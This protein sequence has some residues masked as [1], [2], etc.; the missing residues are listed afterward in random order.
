MTVNPVHLKLMFFFE[1]I[2]SRYEICHF[3]IIFFN[4][5]SKFNS[6]IPIVVVDLVNSLVKSFKS[7]PCS[8]SPSVFQFFD[9]S[10][11]AILVL[12]CYPDT[13]SFFFKTAAH[14]S[15]AHFKVNP[16]YFTNDLVSRND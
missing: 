14:G 10:P 7:S 11:S 4:V 8:D 12:S 1:F 6:D 15:A 3:S 2:D 5:E 9:V 16:F 13:N